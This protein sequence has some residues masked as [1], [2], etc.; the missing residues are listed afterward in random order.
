MLKFSLILKFAKVIFKTLL[1]LFRG[2]F[3]NWLKM[4]PELIKSKVVGKL[5]G[6]KTSVNTATGQEISENY[7][8]DGNQW[9]KTTA[10]RVVELDEIPDEIRRRAV[11]SNKVDVTDD[12]EMELASAS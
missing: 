2:I 11:N 1:S 5:W 10:S 4:V 6:A 9:H 7:S 8:L 3:L 12:L